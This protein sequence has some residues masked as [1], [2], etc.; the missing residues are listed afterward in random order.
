[1]YFPLE[2]MKLNSCL[3]GILFCPA[4]SLNFTSRE[5]KKFLQPII[6]SR[7]ELQIRATALSSSSLQDAAPLPLPLRGL[8]HGGK[9][10]LQAAGGQPGAV[11]GLRLPGAQQAAEAPQHQ[12]SDPQHPKAGAGA[13]H[14]PRHDPPTHP[15]SAASDAAAGP[16]RPAG[17]G[18]GA[19]HDRDHHHHGN[20]A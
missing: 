14:Q 8:R 1:M 12:V 16:V 15:Q 17:G 2:V 18:R 10:D 19:R 9:P 3:V 6:N 4:A 11:L 20:Q 13:E 5:R 7:V